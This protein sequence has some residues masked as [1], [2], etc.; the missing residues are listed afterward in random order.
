MII[1]WLSFIAAVL[2][3]IQCFNSGSNC[4]YKSGSAIYWTS[5]M[6]TDC[7]GSAVAYNPSDTGIDYLSDA[8]SSG[9]WY[10]LYTVGG[11]PV[12]QGS[13]DPQP[14]YY[15]STTSITA[16]SASQSSQCHYAD[17]AI[18]SFIV[19]PGSS[20]FRSNAG[21]TI[22]DFGL[23]Y[24]AHTGLMVYTF[25]GDSGPTSAIGEGSV[26]LVEAIGFNPWNS[27]HTRVVDGVSSGVT[28]LIFTGSGFGQ[29]YIPT[30]R[31]INAHAAGAFA[32]AGGCSLLNT[33]VGSTVSG[34]SLTAPNVQTNLDY[35]CNN[36]YGVFQACNAGGACASASVCSGWGGVW[37]A[38]GGVCSGSANI[39]CC[40]VSGYSGFTGPV[41][42]PSTPAPPAPLAPSCTFQTVVGECV[43]QSTCP[44]TW[45]S[46]DDG[47]TGCE[48]Q[49]AGVRCC[50]ASVG[51]VLS[52][53][54]NNAASQ[55][56]VCSYS[57]HTGTCVST[58]TGGQFR[59]SRQG[60][61]GCESFSSGIK[62]C[63]ASSLLV[64]DA[65]S[66]YISSA[67]VSTNTIIGGIVGAALLIMICVA[68]AVY[69]VVRRS[70]TR[71]R[72]QD[73]MIEVHNEAF[74]MAEI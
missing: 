34:C 71:R 39:G 20:S 43:E 41:P 49:P 47:A 46:S 56:P 55:G 38:A 70:N 48:T 4:V 26:A 16:K 11:E 66:A 10:G 17:A 53:S 61:K 68:I 35:S 14:G 31:D 1:L 19:L 23:V 8:G 7:D 33:A 50:T 6:D 5:K 30:N 63:I 2:A 60:A 13:S 58:C 45:T 62:C 27:A 67:A 73:E 32:A 3:Q 74:N 37:S 18:L 40:S 21:F 65:Y 36:N 64:D 69:F 54:G 42:T 44:G 52:G 24:Y 9:D 72:P 15:V 29:N 59:S 28:Q 25:Y 51:I 12:V 22:G 57:E